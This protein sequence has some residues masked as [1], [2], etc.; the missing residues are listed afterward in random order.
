[1]IILSLSLSLLFHAQPSTST[2]IHHLN[3]TQ[4]FP[5]EPF[6]SFL[7]FLPFPSLSFFLYTFTFYLNYLPTL[8]CLYSTFFQPSLPHTHAR[9][10]PRQ[11]LV[12]PEEE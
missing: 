4:H 2:H 8:P 9:T 5:L 12:A 6:L 7:S 1:M 3:P 10:H 11:A